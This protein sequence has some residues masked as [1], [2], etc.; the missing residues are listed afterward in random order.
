MISLRK[1]TKLIGKQSSNL[2]LK[3][4]TE[5][6]MRKFLGAIT[7]MILVLGQSLPVFADSSDMTAM[8]EGLKQQMAKMQATIDQQNLRIQQL[9][10]SKVLEVSQ[11]S[12]PVKPESAKMSD[13]D[14]EKGVKDNLGK[15]VP[16]LKGLKMGGDFRLRYET[17]NFSDNNPDENTA[18]DRTRNRFR[19]RL[20]YGVE[21][22]FGDDWKVGFRLASATAGTN[23]VATDNTSTNV[24]LGNP[25]YDVYKNIYIDRAYAQY[26]PNGLKDYGPVKGVTIGAGKFDNPF[27]RYST[28]IVWDGDVTP[29]GAYEKV[30]LQLVSTEDTKVN[31][32][33]TL[34]QFIIN[35]NAGVDTDVEMYGYQSALNVS[36]YG[37]GTDTPIDLTGVVSFYEYTNWGQTVAS[38]TAGVSF[39]RTNTLIADDFRILDFYPE[40]QFS[41]NSTPVILWYNFVKNLGNVGTT[42]GAGSLGNDIH[43]QDQAW[44][45]G[46]KIG[47]ASK[48]GQWESFYGYYEIGANSVVAAFNDSDFGGP[49]GAGYTNRQGHKFGVGYALTDSI[50]VNWTGYMVTPLNPNAAIANSLNE[51][52]FRS[53]ADLVYK[54]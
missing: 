3:K 36:T 29:E 43:D 6:T 53:Q 26:S 24:T 19:I 52:V 37:F 14:F 32:Y 35:E 49:G 48:K 10:S 18:S 5:E 45:L 12:M 30:D 15:A 20:R 2:T 17:F 8:L 46:A 39:L 21:K 42:D 41:V 4:G 33:N 9:E 11:P 25:G 44:G 47:K 22:D 1:K 54:F 34:G 13:S 51:T 28:P 27:L 23:G 7:V 31:V 50:M 16:W 40:V 38:N